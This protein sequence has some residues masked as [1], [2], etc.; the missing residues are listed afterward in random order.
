MNKQETITRLVLLLDAAIPALNAAARA[1]EKREEGKS[2]RC[3]TERNRAK[4]AVVLVAEVSEKY[5]IPL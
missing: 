1:E 4:F 2:I 3:I 5:G